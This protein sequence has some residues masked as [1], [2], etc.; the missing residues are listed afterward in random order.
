M[1]PVSTLDLQNAPNAGLHHRI[2]SRSSCSGNPCSGSS[3]TSCKWCPIPWRLPCKSSSMTCCWWLCLRSLGISV[4]G[5]RPTR[6]PTGSRWSTVTSTRPGRRRRFP[7][8]LS[9]LEKM[10]SSQTHRLDLSRSHSLTQINLL[11]ALASEQRVTRA[12]RR[13]H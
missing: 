2:R 12:G 13:V 7:S 11:Q 10:C 1:G 3:R 6:H 8:H 5:R 9:L 4:I